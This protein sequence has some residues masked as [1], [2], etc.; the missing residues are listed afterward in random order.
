MEKFERKYKG[1][2]LNENCLRG[3]MMGEGRFAVWFKDDTYVPFETIKEFKDAV[4]GV[5]PYH[6][7]RSC[8][9]IHDWDN[10][11]WIQLDVTKFREYAL[12]NQVGA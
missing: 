12:A 9:S 4:N 5:N 3:Y 8:V 10:D 1:V 7:I 2:I 6:P 11:K